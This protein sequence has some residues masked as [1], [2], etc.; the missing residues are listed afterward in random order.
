MMTENPGNLLVALSAA[1]SWQSALKHD[2]PMKDSGKIRECVL[3]FGFAFAPPGLSIWIWSLFPDPFLQVRLFYQR[4]DMKIRICERDD[5]ERMLRN[6]TF[7]AYL[8]MW[9]D[10]YPQRGRMKQVKEYQ[11][12]FDCPFKEASRRW[13]YRPPQRNIDF[14][15]GPDYTLR[16]EGGRYTLLIRLN[17]IWTVYK[18]DVEP[19]KVADILRPAREITLENACDKQELMR[20]G[21]AG[22]LYKKAE[23]MSHYYWRDRNRKLPTKELKC[24]AWFCGEEIWRKMR[25]P[26]KEKYRYKNK[27]GYYYYYEYYFLIERKGGQEEIKTDVD[28]IFEYMKRYYEKQLELTR[29]DF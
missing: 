20:A 11:N 21:R 25:R 8:Q 14:E 15:I 13:H 28:A 27:E 1:C 16:R 10:S 26:K 18:E 19:G 7:G 6:G 5:A 22:R 24:S 3:T 4:M 9:L 29:G 23:Y 12:A 17:G 2:L